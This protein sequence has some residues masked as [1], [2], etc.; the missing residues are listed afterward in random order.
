M[1]QQIR[2][3]TASD[4]VRIAYATFG[5]GPPL[6]CVWPWAFSLERFNDRPELRSWKEGLAHRR[7]IVEFDC[8]GAGA[9]QRDVQDLSLEA[10]LADLAAVVDQ[11]GLNSFDL[12][13]GQGGSAV[14]VAYAVRN[15]QRVSRLVLQAPYGC[16]QDRA[17]REALQ[18]TV[19]LIR[20]NWGLARR[21]LAGLIFPSGPIEAQ[22]WWSNLTRENISPEIAALYIEYEAGLDVRDLLPQVQAPTLILHR[23][24]DRVVP[25]GAG[26]AAAALIPNARFVPLEGDIAIYAFDHA[27]VSQL[28]DDFLDEGRPE[29]AAAMAPA[30]A[31]LVTILFTDMEGSTGL[32]QRVGDAKAQELV[33]AHNTIVREAL[34]AHGGAE[35]KHTG[36]GIM[37][38]FPLASSAIDC[39]AAIQRACDSHTREHPETPLRVR[40]GLNAGEPVAEESDLFG[41]AVQLA[42]RVCSHAQPG[43]IVVSDV[44]RQLAAG[45]SFLFSDLGEVALRGFEDPVRLYEVRWE[46]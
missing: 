29:A 32:T 44:V 4:G 8:R 26:R 10:H 22:R 15:P 41:T 45:K 24:R 28:I 7:L 12:L 13:G 36:D 39:A 21:A 33:R 3:C 31:G 38:S 37:A 40:A 14:A 25:M 43:Q 17:P 19:H 46:P 35:I 2:F 42:A 9:S 6:V 1:E 18:G 27:Q 11:L 5:S 34:K 30:P 23:R 16:G 20:T